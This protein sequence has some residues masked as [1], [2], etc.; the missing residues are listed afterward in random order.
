M[1]RFVELTARTL[2]PTDLFG[3]IGGDEF[4][5]LLP[6]AG[7]SQAESVADRVLEQLR[8]GPGVSS[9]ASIGVVSCTHAP[10]QLEGV[11]RLADQLMYMAKR[12][13]GGVVRTTEFDPHP[14]IDL[15]PP[16]RSAGPPV[17]AS[18][19]DQSRSQR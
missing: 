14:T 13:G 8:D 4:A 10:E 3:R 2:R 5:L 7:P 6:G 12:D 9:T 11:V 16:T 19:N 17:D 15:R 1:R 18:E